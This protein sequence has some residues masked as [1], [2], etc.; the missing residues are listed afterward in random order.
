MTQPDSRVGGRANDRSPTTA[1]T[2][3]NGATVPDGSASHP[4]QR[5]CGGPGRQRGAACGGQRHAQT[6]RCAVL[7]RRAVTVSRRR[8]ACRGT[9]AQ[10]RREM[11]LAGVSTTSTAPKGAEPRTRRRT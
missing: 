6:D 10:H 7:G 3:P 2:F 1:T 4:R 8:P 5:N 9:I 11:E